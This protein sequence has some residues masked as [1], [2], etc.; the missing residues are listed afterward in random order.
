VN[1]YVN[2]GL[3]ISKYQWKFPE[4]NNQYIFNG[5]SENYSGISL[6]P[7]EPCQDFYT[8]AVT[9]RSISSLA[10]GRVRVHCSTDKLST[11]VLSAEARRRA[12]QDSSE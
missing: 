7:A 5:D 6:H 12:H 2:R 10:A 1:I 11:T 9:A 4:V 8:T 3:K